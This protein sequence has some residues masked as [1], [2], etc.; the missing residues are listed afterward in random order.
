MCFTLIPFGLRERDGHLVD[1]SIVPRGKQCGCICPSCHTSLVA[2]QGEDREWHFAHASHGVYRETD[3]EC[4]F[5]FY[6]SVRLM[7]KQLI[8]ASCEL[9]LPEYREHAFS[10]FKVGQER[11]NIEYL[12]TREQSVKLEDV[13]VEKSF[14]GIR[15]DVFGKVK[16]YPFGIYFT[17]P[18]RE[19]PVDPERFQKMHIGIIEIDLTDLKDRLAQARSSGST[20]EIALKNFLASDIQSKRWLYHPRKQK[21]Q[22]AAEARL[23]ALLETEISPSC[24]GPQTRTHRTTLAVNKNLFRTAL[25]NKRLHPWI[26]NHRPTI[27]NLLTIELV[28]KTAWFSNVRSMVAQPDWDRLRKETYRAYGYRCGVCG[29][30]GKHHPV[31]CHEIWQYD[32]AKRIQKLM[33][34]IALCPRCHEVKHIGFA[35]TQGRG[36]I[37]TAHLAKVNRWTLAEAKWYVHQQFALWMQRSRL[38]WQMDLGWL[39]D[40]GIPYRDDHETDGFRKQHPK[41]LSAGVFCP[42]RQVG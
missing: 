13:E 41:D 23:A 22:A 3:R 6:L 37:A 16:Q 5:S 2:R 35:N 4:T 38:S 39:K 33:G 17:H 15:I 31:E 24:S 14:Q 27:K 40:R 25:T 10:Y 7:A 21:C 28:P 30:V 18:G 29:G 9:K 8:G 11:R 19:Q 36:A 12:I 34:L 42:I 32:D 20:Y 1:V 26:C